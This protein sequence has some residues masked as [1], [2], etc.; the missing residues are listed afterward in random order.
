MKADLPE[1]L[2]V[3][4][5]LHHRASD[6]HH[7]QPAVSDLL[8]LQF[9]HLRE[10][11]VGW[12]QVGWSDAARVSDSCYDRNTESVGCIRIRVCFVIV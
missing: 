8:R 4:E 5:G 11:G 2:V 12:G 7:G 9:K 3:D 10:D 6:G 1:R